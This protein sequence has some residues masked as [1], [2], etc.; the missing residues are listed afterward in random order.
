MLTNLASAYEARPVCAICTDDILPDDI[1]SK[2]NCNHQY[3]RD[4][5]QPWLDA[6][7]MTFNAHVMT[8]SLLSAVEVLVLRKE[9]ASALIGLFLC[10]KGS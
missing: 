10:I 5:L 9:I 6:N 1:V 8:K 4:C 2:L 7:H 3:P